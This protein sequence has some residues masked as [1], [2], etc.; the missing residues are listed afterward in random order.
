[1]D[2][3]HPL[4]RIV[5]AWV[6]FALEISVIVARGVSGACATFPPGENRHLNHILDQTIVPA[7]IEPDLAMRAEATARHIAE[8]LDLAPELEARALFEDL[9]R[10]RPEG[11]GSRK[12]SRG[13]MTCPRYRA[14]QR[15]SPSR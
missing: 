10:R 13:L 11:Y 12:L 8:R 3:V 2:R 5:E 14:S 1:M 6:E 15:E 9:L 4:D 7:R